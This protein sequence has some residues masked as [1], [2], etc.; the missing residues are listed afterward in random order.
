MK[1]L[2]KKII[3]S[4][5]TFEARILLKRKN[6]TII[7]VTGSV[8]KTSTKDAIYVAIKN[9]VNAR[10]SAK[11]YNSDIGVPL[12]ILGLSSGWSNPLIWLK[13]IVDGLFIAAFSR[14]Y[15]KVL[16]L[17]AGI[18]RPGDMANLTKWLRPNIAVIT[19]LPNVPVHVEFFDTPEAVVREKMKLVDALK[20][21]GVVVY[22]HDDETI[23]RELEHVRHKAIGFSRYSPS[24][25]TVT[26]DK[27]VYHDNSPTGMEF[28]LT[29]LNESTTVT[30]SGVIGVQHAYN[31]AAAAAVASQ[32]DIPFEAISTAMSSFSP[33]PGRMRI[34]PGL[35]S[36]TILDD[37]YNSSPIAAE[38]ALMT[39]QEVRSSGRKIAVLGDMLELGRYSVNEHERIGVTAAETSDMLV[40][41]GVR[42]RRTAQAALENGL[43]E[44]FVFQ[45]DD[46]KRAGRELQN[47]IQPGDVILIKGSQGIRA[48]RVVLE[49]MNE[50]DRANELLVRQEE[51]WQTP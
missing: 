40:T 6:P 29:H 34:I 26:A 30:I 18:D 12:S 41:I 39:L 7:A 35:K 37:T 2:F 51:V 33:P 9:S 44:K 17:E 16:V 48:E 42:S 14:R 15:P 20:P 5:I 21:D 32:F 8:G 36:T 28:T 10:K 49:I 1:Q 45:Y 25:F 24:H 11:T 43:S 4:I 23:R 47:L 13:N 22:N 27:I 3:V 19:R 31:V 38:R 46:E 50:P